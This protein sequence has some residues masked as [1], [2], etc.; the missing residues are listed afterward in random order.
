MLSFVVSALRSLRWGHEHA[1]VRERRPACEPRV[2][3][4]LT[5]QIIATARR[6]LA[7]EGAA[8]LSLRAVARELGMASSAVYRYVASRDELLTLLIVDAYDALGE[9]VER[10][11]AKVPRD[12]LSSTGTSRSAPPPAAGRCAARTSSR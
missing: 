10:A 1:T 8:G 2:R 3:E 12:E 9:A 7:T 4:E 5:L 11:E 6:H